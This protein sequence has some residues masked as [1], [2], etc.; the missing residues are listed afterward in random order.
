M[1]KYYNDDKDYY[2]IRP[3]TGIYSCRET[4]SLL[5]VL[6]CAVIYERGDGYGNLVTWSMCGPGGH[7]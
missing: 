2:S 6:H 7:R 5:A 1:L 3:Q 4:T